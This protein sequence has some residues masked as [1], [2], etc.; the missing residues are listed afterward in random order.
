MAGYVARRLMLAVPTV[1]GITFLVFLLVAL[2]PGGVGAAMSVS[3]A[4]QGEASNRAVHEAYL[5]DRYGL[6]DPVI[7]QYLRWLGRIS[8]LKF[9]RRAQVSSSGERFDPPRALRPP[10]AL[11]WFDA[12]PAT[13]GTDPDP[14]ET[15]RERRFR[16]AQQEYARARAAYVSATVELENRLAAYARSAGHAAVVSRSGRVDARRFADAE[17]VRTIVEWIPLKRAGDAA[18]VAYREAEAAR[19]RLGAA[20]DAT[21]F[22]EAGVS[23]IPGVLWLGPPDLGV[24]FARGQPVGA[25]IARALPV[26]LLLNLLALPIIYTV[27]IP[28]GLFAGARRGSAIDSGLGFVFLALYS[29]PVVLAGVLAVGFLARDQYLGWF[30][31]A[32]LTSPAA[33]AM[34]YLPSTGPDGVW[35]RGYLLDLLWHVALPVMC[36][37][38]GGFAVLAKQTRGAL[39]EQLNA[40]YIR[41]ARA[42]GVGERDILLRHAF[43]NSLLPLITIFT[44]VF[45]AMLAGSVV[46]ERIFSVP[47]MGSLLLQAIELRDREIV[48]AV[49]LIAGIVN[50]A[51]MLAA[52]VL[53]AA[54]DPRVTYR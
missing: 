24:S 48:L 19:A 9:G 13:T 16:V 53:Y 42:K 38:Y 27:A 40:D 54:A 1:L 31:E 6:N 11:G 21:P 30:P 12:P 44:S 37:T 15:D 23:L 50:V 3:G 22:R 17:P 29:I 32:G 46:V 33:D 28:G 43:R 36:L 51:A 47:G 5:E 10:K 8:P 45:P 52:D 14:S 26:T 4:G 7:A 49:T 18:A 2:A 34:T 41:T 35:Q 25:L 39:L 20:F